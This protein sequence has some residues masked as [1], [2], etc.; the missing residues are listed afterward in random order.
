[1]GCNPL[2]FDLD[3]PVPGEACWEEPVWCDRHEQPL[4]PADPECPGC[5]L[6]EERAEELLER[7]RTMKRGWDE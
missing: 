7:E 4:D 2:D 1:M 5:S 3:Y 6:E